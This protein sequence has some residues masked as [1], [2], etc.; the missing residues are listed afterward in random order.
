MIMNPIPVVT[1]DGPSGVGKGSVS[2]LLA[3]EL[4]WHFLDS[5]AL[6][7]VL[8]LAAEEKFIPLTD[9]PALG[10]LASE[11]PIRFEVGKGDPE[12]WLGN[13]DV[14]QE[15]RTPECGL[16]A[17]QVAAFP[18]VRQGLLSRQRGFRQAPGLV[19]DGRDMGTVVFPDAT[20]KFFLQAS[21]EE[22]A[23]R[24]YLQLKE[25]AINVNLATLLVD[26]EERDRRD[27]ERT[28]S[29]L[30]PASDALLID[31]TVLTLQ[32]VFNQVLAEVKARLGNQ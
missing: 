29:P 8:A 2:L 25:N 27:R 7:R 21:A 15:I 12:I 19:A 26:I 30:R 23:K 5:G 1:I 24:R 18:E 16:I 17:S 31:T 11:M 10:Q 32:E 6:Y 3:K 4:K 9:G 14:T 22:R 28:S 20:V 13:R